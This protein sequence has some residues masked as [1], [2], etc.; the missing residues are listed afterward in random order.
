MTALG[1]FGSAV[2]VGG[3]T[4]AVVLALILTGGDRG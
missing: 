4:L 1:V 2:L 3:V